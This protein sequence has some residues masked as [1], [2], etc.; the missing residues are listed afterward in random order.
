M[1][2]SYIVSSGKLFRSWRLKEATWSIDPFRLILRIA[3]EN[4]SNRFVPSL[5]IWMRRKRRCFFAFLLLIVQIFPTWKTNLKHNFR[6]GQNCN[7]FVFIIFLF[8]GII[9]IEQEKMK[10]KIPTI[11]I[12]RQLT[13]KL[14]LKLKLLYL[15]IFV[16][17]K[18]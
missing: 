2:R 3:S 16:Y 4:T 9:N 17:N 14:Y 1:I 18:L 13:Y 8:C 6:S 15:I 12:W 11:Q 7:Y 10:L 5:P